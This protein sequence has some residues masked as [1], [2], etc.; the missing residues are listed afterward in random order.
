MVKQIAWPLIC[1]SIKDPWIRH[2][3]VEWVQSQWKVPFLPSDRCAI[4]T[5]ILIAAVDPSHWLVIYIDNIWAG[6]LYSL[7]LLSNES[8]GQS[9]RLDPWRRGEHGHDFVVFPGDQLDTRFFFASVNLRWNLKCIRKSTSKT[10]EWQLLT[11]DQMS[12]GLSL[13]SRPHQ[14][15]SS[16]CGLFGSSQWQ[17][18]PRNLSMF[19]IMEMRWNNCPLWHGEAWEM[20]SASSS[21]LPCGTRRFLMSQNCNPSLAPPLFRDTVEIDRYIPSSLLHTK[22]VWKI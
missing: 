17:W 13:S 4:K 20:E 10:C 3:D 11:C 21:N 22:T 14:S 18:C 9:H 12:R 5:N 16:E 1:K 19:V 6:N 2:R 15:E 8:W 7:S